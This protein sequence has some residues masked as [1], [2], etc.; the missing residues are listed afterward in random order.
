MDLEKYRIELSIKCKNGLDFICSAGIIWLVISY[1]WTLNTSSYN[2]SIYTFMVGALMLPLAFLLSKI[3][4]TTWTLKS[5]P[6]DS[7]GLLFNISQLFYFPFLFF[8]LF[9]FSDHFVMVYVIITGGHFFLYSWY[10]KTSLYA[11]AAGLSTL[12]ALILGLKLP[13]DNL[14]VIPLSFSILLILLGILLYFDYKRK[15][16]LATD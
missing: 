8:A 2:K 4:K 12:G 3:F 11:F 1:I 16:R 7:L 9:R 15:A 10:Y 14:Y 5:N 6:L 13:V